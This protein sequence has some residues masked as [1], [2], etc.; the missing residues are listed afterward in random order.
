MEIAKPFRHI[1][2]RTRQIIKKSQDLKEKFQ[3]MEELERYRR[4]KYPFEMLYPRPIPLIKLYRE[5]LEDCYLF[6]QAQR[7]NYFPRGKTEELPMTTM[8]LRN[9]KR[10]EALKQLHSIP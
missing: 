6:R 7:Y 3:V 4:L 2:S 8:E 5:A 9:Q 1:I 10:R